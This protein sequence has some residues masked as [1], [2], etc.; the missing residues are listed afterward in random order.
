[1]EALMNM[2]PLARRILLLGGLTLLVTACPSSNISG[3]AQASTRFQS[4]GVS[5]T[6]T[7]PRAE[8]RLAL[9]ASVKEGQQVVLSSTGM[10]LQ[11][12][13]LWSGLDGSA[14]L[15]NPWL[16]LKLVEEREG[17]FVGE[18]IFLARETRLSSAAVSF[19]FYLP[20]SASCQ[21]DGRECAATYRF[22]LERQ[23]PPAQGTVDVKWEATGYAVG[24]GGAGEDIE[25]HLVPV[26]TSPAP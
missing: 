21:Q 12:Q 3:T 19:A 10:S 15:V 7:A 11:V 23:G 8:Q 2:A 9:V 14:S 13:F 1:M 20:N 24:D 17:G 25:V 4:E 6:P 18:E 16:R 22:E 5:L 26:V